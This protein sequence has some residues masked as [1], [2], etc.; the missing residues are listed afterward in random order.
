MTEKPRSALRVSDLHVQVKSAEGTASLVRHLDFE[1]K[2]GEVLG[3]VGE[4]GCG[5]TVTS[6]SL[7][8]LLNRKTTSVEGS[9]RLNGRELN[10]IRA[11]E[12][13]R[14]RGK[15]IAL[16]MQNPMNAF[17]P[18]FTIGDQ[19]VESIRTHTDLTKKQAAE[20]AAASLEGVNLPNAS[21]LMRRYP[22]QL[23]GGM[24][25]RV[26]IAVSMCLRPSVLIA[27]EPTTALDA[28]NQLQVLRQLD[29]LRREY[30]TAILL[31]SHDLGVIAEMA[32]EVAVMQHGR[33]VEKADVYRL[34]DHPQQEYTKQLLQARP[35]FPA[36][37]RTKERLSS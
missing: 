22:F 25:Q 37:P 30:G 26:M 32:D 28:V 18:V 29:R 27:D 6:L 15:E 12:M 33:I 1:L 5:K 35:A 2:P 11:E 24:L 17:S 19:F 36:G 21:E 14:L 34:F 23:S 4:S 7:L 10:G 16:I 20:L 9:I 31:I 13:R 8:Q 3:L